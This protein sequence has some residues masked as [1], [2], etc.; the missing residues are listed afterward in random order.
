LVGSPIRDNIDNKE[1]TKK[2]VTAIFGKTT[3]ALG[4]QIRKRISGGWKI[5]ALL[6]P[7]IEPGNVIVVES[8][9]IPAGSKFRVIEV[10]HIGD[11]HGPDWTSTIYARL[12]A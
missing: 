12:M 1:Y 8:D 7:N 5:K 4:K 6:Q 2:E 9:E 11:T 3:T 10:E